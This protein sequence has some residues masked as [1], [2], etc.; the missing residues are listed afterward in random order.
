MARQMAEKLADSSMAAAVWAHI[1]R[2]SA[3]AITAELQAALKSLP[4][5]RQVV[6]KMLEIDSM[7][8]WYEAGASPVRAIVCMLLMQQRMSCSSFMSQLVDV[9]WDTQLGLHLRL[10]SCSC[11]ASL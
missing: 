5:L 7:Q 4:K 8:S 3:E 6:A 10:F 1:P 9:L 11:L 2:S